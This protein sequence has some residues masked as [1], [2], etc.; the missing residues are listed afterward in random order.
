MLIVSS[1]PQSCPQVHLEAKGRFQ[2]NKFVCYYCPMK[3]RLI[4]SR[5]MVSIAILGLLLAPIAR[6]AIA[7]S[8]DTMDMAEMAGMDM[9]MPDDMP[10][11]LDDVPLNP[12]KDCDQD[13]PF[14]ILCMAAS[15]LNLPANV[16]PLRPR[17]LANSVFPDYH[18]HF[19]SLSYDPPLR[20]P[21][22]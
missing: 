8:A 5:F 7:M 16:E 12:T 6:P 4:L 17:N 2:Y 15:S 3:L 21:T 13:C 1:C 22:V 9:P 11:C 20:P 14:I 18:I 19:N 10:C